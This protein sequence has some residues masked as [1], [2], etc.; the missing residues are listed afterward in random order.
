MGVISQVKKVFI[1]AQKLITD[2]CT[3]ITKNVK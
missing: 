1:F 2:E 3:R